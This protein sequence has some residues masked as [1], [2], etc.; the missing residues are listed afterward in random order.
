LN[1]SINSENNNGIAGSA[2]NIHELVMR[3]EGEVKKVVESEHYYTFI[4]KNN[5]S[6]T[7]KSH[8]NN[9]IEAPQQGEA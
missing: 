5:S 8:D 4:M 2:R 1:I 7:N 6:K 3:E 9:A